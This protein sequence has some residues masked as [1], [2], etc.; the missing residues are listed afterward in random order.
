MAI[1]NHIKTICAII[2][3]A[4]IAIA[5]KHQSKLQIDSIW[6][7]TSINA[8]SG[9]SLLQDSIQVA[10]YNN[11][12]ICIIPFAEIDFKSIPIGPDTDSLVPVDTRYKYKFFVYQPGDSIAYFFDSLNSVSKHLPLD[13]LL[14]VYITP[15]TAFNENGDS[16]I[17]VQYDAAK[18]YAKRTLAAKGKKD[19]SWPDSTYIF[20]TPAFTKLKYPISKFN[21]QNLQ[22][23]KIISVFNS[24]TVRIN[25][26]ITNQRVEFIFEV[27]EISDLER[28]RLKYLFDKYG[29]LKN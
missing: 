28:K 6:M 22:A 15:D 24:T 13:S 3:I 20:Y 27:N 21:Y 29:S 14:K 17:H 11:R 19:A 26:V 9:K 25:N 18:Q 16:L 5:C 10:S 1:N 4:Q 23:Y 8:D 7:I 12:N 2:L